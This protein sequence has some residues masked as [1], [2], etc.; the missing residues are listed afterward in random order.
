M[1]NPRD[2]SGQIL[3]N[4]HSGSKEQA[5]TAALAA[6][7]A[8]PRML[9][10]TWVLAWQV[11]TQGKAVH[12]E[13]RLCSWCRPHRL[14]RHALSGRKQDHKVCS[15]ASPLPPPPRRSIGDIRHSKKEVSAQFRTKPNNL[16]HRRLSWKGECA[17]KGRCCVIES[18]ERGTANSS[19]AT[20]WNT[21]SA[22]PKNI[23]PRGESSQIWHFKFG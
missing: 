17:S 16:K 9:T 12:T 1:L 11:G 15:F 18:K 4:D 8:H 19:T 5:A 3:F 23:R 21:H 13:G 22:C 7:T 6:F 2:D 10:A 20:S 14:A